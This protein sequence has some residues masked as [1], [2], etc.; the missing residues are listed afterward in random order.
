LDFGSQNS[1]VSEGPEHL[2][3]DQKRQVHIPEHQ[4]GLSAKLTEAEASVPFGGRI[5]SYLSPYEKGEAGVNDVLFDLSSVGAE[6]SQQQYHQFP[7]RDLLSSKRRLVSIKVKVQL[8][9]STYP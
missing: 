6:L 4:Y 8:S 5:L 2:P 3:E 1:F 9:L 7:V